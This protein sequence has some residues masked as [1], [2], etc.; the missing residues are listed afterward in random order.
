MYVPTLIYWGRQ[1]HECPVNLA[2]QMA[3]TIPSARLVELECGHWV[4]LAL[5]RELALSLQQF[6][7]SPYATAR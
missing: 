5:P 3:E 7:S 1:D 6:W 2:Y 4:P